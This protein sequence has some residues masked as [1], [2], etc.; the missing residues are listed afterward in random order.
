M[1]E[2][3]SSHMRKYT[4]QF[5]G[6][7]VDFRRGVAGGGG[8]GAAMNSGLFRL[9]WSPGGSKEHCDDGDEH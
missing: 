4:S 6:N 1:R 9:A 5:A 7:G 3:M 8:S 2:Y